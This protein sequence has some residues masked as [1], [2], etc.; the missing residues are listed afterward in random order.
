MYIQAKCVHLECALNDEKSV[1][2]DL[3]YTAENLRS[4]LADLEEK[5]SK[6]C[7]DY[8]EC[9]HSLTLY[10]RSCLSECLGSKSN[11]VVV[12]I[13]WKCG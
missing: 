6:Q 10:V 9:Q 8:S 1:S 7:R 3:R 11:E 4:E 2:G 13:H 5:Y 12:P